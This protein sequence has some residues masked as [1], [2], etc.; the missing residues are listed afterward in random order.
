[1]VRGRLPIGDAPLRRREGHVR[2]RNQVACIKEV[3]PQQ[4]DAVGAPG[5]RWRNGLATFPVGARPCTA[6][7]GGRSRWSSARRE[8]LGWGELV[9]T[10]DQAQL[11]DWVRARRWFYEFVLPDGSVTDCDAMEEVR[12]LHRMR[13][14]AMKS[15]CADVFGAGLANADAI[16]L[17]SHEGWF[18][19]ELART[20]RSVRGYDVNPASVEAAQRMARLQGVTNVAFTHCDIRSLDG[21]AA[22]PA[23]AVLMYGLLYHVEDPL[24]FL[25]IAAGLARRLLLI[26]T[27]VTGVELE[28]DVEFGYHRWMRP[29][30]GM[31]ALIDDD[32]NREGGNTGLALI[33]STRALNHCLD[34]L[35]FSRVEVFPVPAD[36]PEQLARKRRVIVAGIR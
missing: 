26:E 29:V 13:R 23:D 7:D 3:R 25:R 9:M 30:H 11:L 34:R 1:M 24:R 8:F 16:D 17:A 27:Q 35:G 32:D 21:A 18:A 22:A 5:A 28:M 6:L 33:P 20:V 4:T 10:D 15:V 2:A 31:F 14:D 12:A 36:G 19:L